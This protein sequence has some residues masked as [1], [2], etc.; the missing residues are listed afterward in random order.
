MDEIRDKLDWFRTVILP[1]RAALKARLHSLRRSQED[2]DDLLSEVLI[3]AYANPRWSEVERGRAYLFTVARNL[4]IDQVRREKV[5]SFDTATDLDLLQDGQDLEAQL[6]ARDQL[7]RL[8]AVVEALP[9]QCRRVFILRRIHQ[10][11]PSEIAVEMALSVSTVE[12]H[13]AKAIRLFMQAVA[14]QE[15]NSVDH[16]QFQSARG[17]RAAGR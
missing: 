15:D 2:L 17:D 7:M 10:K 5:V 14:E 4:L 3:R 16:G 8:N 1:H 12:K 11:T 13:L 6:F 9:A